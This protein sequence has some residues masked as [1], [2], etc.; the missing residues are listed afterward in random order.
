MKKHT[1]LELEQ[2]IV[3]NKKRLLQLKR[4]LPSEEIKKDYSLKDWNG[5]DVKFSELFGDKDDLILVHNMGTQ[6]PYCT[7]WA[8]GFNGLVKHLENRTS[9]VVVSPDN[10]RIQK[11]FAKSRGW[12]F[13]MLS[14][15][16]TSFIRDMGFEKPKRGFMPGVSV[17]R[18]ERD[19]SIFRVA[20][21]QFGPGD[22]YCIIWHFFDLLPLGSN[23]W[24]PRF[25]Y[26]KNKNRL[27]RYEI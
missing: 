16:G 12:K 6:C 27:D 24:E 9:F 17:Y 25:S 20:V 18:K 13:R 4:R 2:E 22:D 3:R 19:G 21:D 23:G 5:R 15:H 10:P 1:I 11:E 14:G 26:S 7:L 8:D